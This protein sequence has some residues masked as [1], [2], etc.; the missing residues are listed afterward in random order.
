M[1]HF[2][3]GDLDGRNLRDPAELSVHSHGEL[4]QLQILVRE[5]LQN[6]A[7]NRANGARVRVDFRLL[8]LTGKEK[9]AFLDA[10]HFNEIAP[11]LTAVREEQ[12]KSKGKSFLPDPNDVLSGD[13]ILKVLAIDD[14]RSIGLIGPE[15]E[16]ESHLFEGIP[17]TF[18]GLCRN[19]GD[20][21]KV[22]PVS[23]GTHGIGKSVLWKNSRLKLVLFYSRMTVPYEKQPSADNH[24]YRFFGQCRLPGHYVREEPYRGEG[25]FGKRDLELTWSFYD[26]E[27]ND[28]ATKLGIPL[29]NIEDMSGTSIL[30]IDF[31]DPDIPEMAE[32]KAGTAARIREA[33][34]TYFWPAIVDSRL[35]VY[36]STGEAEAQVA[37]PESRHEI[38]PFIKAYKTAISGNAEPGLEP[39]FIDIDLPSGPD[40]EKRGK[41]RLTVV[42]RSGESEL[43][44]NINQTFINRAALIRGAGMV[45]GYWRVARRGLGG[46][47]F[48]AVVVGGTA[49]PAIGDNWDQPRLEKL[50]AWAEPVTHDTWTP[51]AEMLRGWHGAQSAIRHMRDEI[52][53]VISGSTTVHERPEGKA[54]PLLSKMFPVGTGDTTESEPRD[55]HIDVTK[56]PYRIDSSEE[57]IECYGFEIKVKVPGRRQFRKDPKPSKWRVACKYGFYGEGRRR[58]IIEHAKSRFTAAKNSGGEWQILETTLQIDAE[59]EN[60][61]ADEATICELRGVTEPLDPTLAR[62]TKHDLEIAVFRGHEEEKL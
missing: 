57:G 12:I 13:Y 40:N 27:A 14:Y 29:R 7:D 61:I 55:I 58:K 54:A 22:L 62:T 39:A 24:W 18:M 30:I 38:L 17:H 28:Y 48:H 49:C 51:N 42:T 5:V 6:S 31:D 23:G 34:E 36:I 19:V 3:K 56:E 2:S 15:Y 20:S 1:W 26:E 60:F 25:Y 4:S 43:A 46:R 45:V 53:K 47:D 52:N 33:A 21:Q 41:A 50:L 8:Y 35:E 32:D 44:Y 10:M 37:Q 11:H 59:Y 9:G 16:K